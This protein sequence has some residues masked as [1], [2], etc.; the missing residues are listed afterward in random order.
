MNQDTVKGG[1]DL[2][3]ASPLFKAGQDRMAGIRFWPFF[4]CILAFCW[5]GSP[6]TGWLAANDDP[7]CR[8]THADAGVV[9]PQLTSM[10]EKYGAE[11]E[12]S[13]DTGRNA[14]VVHGPPQD[15]Q[16]ARQLIRTLDKRSV[17]RV[18]LAQRQQQGTVRGYGVEAEHLD[19][20]VEKLR[21]EFPPSTG[22]RIE[23][24]TRTS[25][26]IVIAP[27]A[28]H[29]RIKDHLGRI[30]SADATATGAKGLGRTGDALSSYRL[31]NISGAELEE[32]L[33]ALS[34]NRV[35][36]SADEQSKT[37][38]LYTSADPSGAPSLRID[39]ATN[40]VNLTSSPES[41]RSWRRVLRALD[42]TAGPPMVRPSSFLCAAPIPAKSARRSRRSAMR[43]FA[44]GPAKPPP[45][46]PFRAP[47]AFPI[48]STWPP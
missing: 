6:L 36:I 7:T 41:N 33:R 32:R 25:Q 2:V 22:V 18:V 37:T 34:G 13:I 31:R 48:A 19:D 12:V 47:I 24:D 35:R 17:S 26:I 14:L 15:R 11:A 27:K 9:A 29:D 46:F 10:L 5:L 16:L 21:Q 3:N 42:H 1:G 38:A 40:V 45:R 43:L 30:S 39:H 44:A 23:G 4:L 28:T 20:L 8:L